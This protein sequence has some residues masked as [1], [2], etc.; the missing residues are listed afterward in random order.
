M[1]FFFAIS[2]SLVTL[3][4]THRRTII[5]AMLIVL[6]FF[7][8]YA[9]RPAPA[10]QV[11]LSTP[12]PYVTTIKV[13]VPFIT[14]KVVTKYIKVEDRAEADALLKENKNLKIK[15]DE[16]TVSLA[17]WQSK[18]SGTSTTT[19]VPATST[20][21]QE[22]RVTFKD[23]RLD[24]LSVNNKVSYTLTQKYSIVNTV[25]RDRQN[26]PTNLVRLY[27]IGPNNTR[28]LIPTIETTTVA[29]GQN[30]P[31]LY[32]KLTVQGGVG[33]MN[34]QR[35]VVLT[36]WLKRGRTTATEDTRWAFATPAISLSGQQ[37]AIGVAP[38]SF[39]IGSFPRQPLTNLWVSPFLGTTTGTG[40]NQKGVVFSVT[41]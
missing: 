11:T 17:Y 3:V 2:R 16:L 34:G 20:T 32:T 19:I 31:H 18:G 35:L 38:V 6:A 5:T 1:P 9:Q 8:G 36:P 37:Q 39:N 4:N 33:Y 14:E 26:V 23:W 12:A 10:D 28:T 24:F 13:P 15:V 22:V 30:L 29:T 40:I 27:E 7:I 41:F 25:G 21:P